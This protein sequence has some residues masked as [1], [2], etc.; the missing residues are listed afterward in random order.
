MERDFK[1]V[2]IP[3][4]IWMDESLTVM[5]KMLLV[6]VDSLCG[7]KGCWASNQHLAAFLH[8]SKDRVSKLISGLVKKEYLVITIKYVPGTKQV[9]ERVLFTTIGYRRKQLGGIGEN[10][11]TPPVEN[12]DTPIGENNEESNTGLSNT[13]LSNTLSNTKPTAR[14]NG[15]EQLGGS[16]KI[17]SLSQKRFEEFWQAYPRK[18]GKGAAEKSY[19]KIKPDPALQNRIMTAVA[20]AKNSFNWRK[21]NGQFIPNP[22]T[23]LNQR[24][25]E[26]DLT[27]DSVVGAAINPQADMAREAIEA[28]MNG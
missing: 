28:I 17:P 11:D 6:E 9:K 21:D 15:E 19:A 22:A 1:G 20:V 23:W 2:W 26:D 16:E 4:D 3:K 12:T 13:S 7:E 25:W 14:E 8:V 5:E 24:R 27:P 18:V 10:T